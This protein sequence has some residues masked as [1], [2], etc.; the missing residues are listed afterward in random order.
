MFEKT[1]PKDTLMLSNDAYMP[2]RKLKASHFPLLQLI[3]VSETGIPTA[4]VF[5]IPVGGINLS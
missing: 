2:T 5:S 3:F 4:F 1:Y